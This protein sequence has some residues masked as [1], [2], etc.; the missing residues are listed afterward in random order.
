VRYG[1]VN[2]GHM[3]IV[4]YWAG[5]DF[6]VDLNVPACFACHWESPR[7]HW[8]WGWFE[9]AHIIPDCLGGSE[10]P[11]NLV[12]LCKRCHREAPNCSDPSLM[13]QWMRDRE[14]YWS[15]VLRTAA[16]QCRLSGLSGEE[17]LSINPDAMAAWLKKRSKMFG[18]HPVGAWEI[19]PA[20]VQ[21]GALMKYYLQ[22]RDM[23]PEQMGLNLEATAA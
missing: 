21:V 15:W 7:K 4:K 14:W 11:S 13:I 17:V 1:S 23:P 2:T 20:A 12:L 8:N 5:R 22:R 6:D 9:R 16:D 19:P 3:S 18:Y 10:E